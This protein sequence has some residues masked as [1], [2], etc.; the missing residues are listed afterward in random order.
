MS[1]F[2]TGNVLDRIEMSPNLRGSLQRAMTYA[3]EQSHRQVTLEHLLLALVD[4]R[5]AAVILESSSV[6]VP[7]L[8]TDVSDYLGRL[9]DRTVDGQRR[10]PE[11]GGDVQHIIQS[12][13][14]AAQKSQR[15]AVSSALVLAA[16]VGDGRSPS[17]QILRS[18]GLTFENAISAL[19]QANAA[20]SPRPGQQP[21]SGSGIAPGP[22]QPSPPQPAAPDIARPA[23][24]PATLATGPTLAA[25]PPPPGS[26]SAA[27]LQNMQAAHEII[28]G[29]RERIAAARGV[30]ASRSVEPLASTPSEP[31]PEGVPQYVDQAPVPE[32]TTLATAPSRVAPS[33][34]TGQKHTSPQPSKQAQ[35]VTE[36][37][38]A[39]AAKAEVAPR[40]DR[41]NASTPG[42]AC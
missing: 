42:G 17:A 7:A 8:R 36:P 34:E 1:Q 9:D 22:A 37:V 23:P 35:P 39:P 26:G 33:A 41:T 27:R 16:V 29:A 25:K 6:N 2:E 12:A 14:A 20:T 19:K 18:H 40:P 24:A 21:A 5:E 15:R 32:V 4:D 28:A 11:L 13:G 30:I 31:L 38:V 3:Y 10:Q